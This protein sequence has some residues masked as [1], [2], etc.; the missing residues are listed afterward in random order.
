LPL[1]SV[2][3]RSLDSHRRVSSGLR[4]GHE[5]FG[6]DAGELIGTWRTEV[7]LAGR[8]RV[9]VSGFT[10]RFGPFIQSEITLSP[11]FLA[12]GIDLS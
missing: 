8:T 5:K 11:P 1:S 9:G 2:L 3:A 12:G 10:A 7:K 6:H 4:Q